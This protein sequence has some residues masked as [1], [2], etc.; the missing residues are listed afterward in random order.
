MYLPDLATGGPR[1][2]AEGKGTLLYRFIFPADFAGANFPVPWT[3]GKADSVIHS[4]FFTPSLLDE[5]RLGGN[6]FQPFI[7]SSG[8]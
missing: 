4:I 5:G 2:F 6:G 3:T 8:R 7:F 1:P